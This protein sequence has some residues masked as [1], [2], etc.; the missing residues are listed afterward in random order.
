MELLIIRHGQSEA[1]ILKRL[2]GRADFEL[3][4][5]GKIQAKSMADW[6]NNNYKPDYILSSTLKRARQT[7]EILESRVK[8]KT[9]Y[10]DELM[11]FNNGL[12][13]GLTL[14]EADTRFPLPKDKKPHDSFYEQ[15]T[16]IEF[17][18][19]AETIFSKIVHGFPNDKRVA[20]VSHGNMINMLFRCFLE[21]P[22]TSNVSIHTADTGIHLWRVSPG[23]RQIVFLNSTTHLA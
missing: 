1:D 23:N 14:E 11:E 20:V 5:L 18:A 17:R 6:V 8:L 2:E 21:L 12:V 22:L 4:D 16:L 13:A 9:Q 3:T 19:R 15:E 7:A 10:S